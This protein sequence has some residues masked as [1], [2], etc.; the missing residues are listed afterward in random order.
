MPASDSNPSPAP[1]P[2]PPAAKG[3]PIRRWIGRSFLRVFGWEVEGGA[4][5]VRRAVVIAYPHTSNW[6]LPF[7]LACAWTL[8]LDIRWLG[9]KVLFRPPYGWAMRLLG[10]IAVD[11]SQRTKLVDAVIDTLAPLSDCL[12]V[13]PPEGTRGR[14]GRWKSG[15]YWVAHGADIPIILGYLDYPRRR[16]GLVEMLH[17]SGDLAAD[18]ETIK[19]YYDGVEGKHPDKQGA[20]TLVDPP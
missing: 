3:R 17:P 18:F 15:F 2:G 9:K 8:D 4:L 13:I 11:R 20:I 12:V 10:G 16:G 19:A 5:D 7:T 14:A 6:D 1:T